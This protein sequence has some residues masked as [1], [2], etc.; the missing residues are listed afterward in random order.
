MEENK[1]NGFKNCTKLQATS[2]FDEYMDRLSTKSGKSGYIYKLRSYKD[3]INVL[4]GYSNT[5][6]INWNEICRA[7]GLSIHLSDFEKLFLYVNKNDRSIYYEYCRNNCNAKQNKVIRKR[8]KEY[9]YTDYQHKKSKHHNNS[10]NNNNNNNNSSSKPR[11]INNIGALSKQ[12]PSVYKF[13]QMTIAQLFKGHRL[14]AK[15][16]AKAALLFGLISSESY[17]EFKNNKYTIYDQNYDT[18][19]GK[20]PS[21]KRKRYK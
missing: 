16:P 10:N 7:T 15:A 14:V 6:A 4:P 20:A 13:K 2:F 18:F 19:T 9:Y 17:Q 8:H 1:S 11:N 5:D 12:D 21:K 3:S